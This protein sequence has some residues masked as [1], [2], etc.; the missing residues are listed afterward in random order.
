M[1]NQKILVYGIAPRKKL[2]E[3]Q[4]NFSATS[5]KKLSLLPNVF[6]DFK[7]C[8]KNLIFFKMAMDGSAISIPDVK[9]YYSIYPESTV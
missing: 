3:I 9:I 7:S 6:K 8:S 5:L 1:L 2:F 4:N